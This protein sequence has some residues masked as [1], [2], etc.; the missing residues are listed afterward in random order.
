MQFI[1]LIKNRFV[2]DAFI[3]SPV[4]QSL[5]Q[6]GVTALVRAAQNGNP[7][8]VQVLLQAG[9]AIGSQVSYEER[10]FQRTLT[11]LLFPFDPACTP[12]GRRYRTHE[13]CR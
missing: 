4:H 13:G 9:V 12:V 5:P 8:V 1:S 11:F 10:T 2:C 3:I 7:N 6:H